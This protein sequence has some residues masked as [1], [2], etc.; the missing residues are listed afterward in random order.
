MVVSDR[1]GS[2]R[3]VCFLHPFPTLLHWMDGWAGVDFSCVA[4]RRQPFLFRVKG[5][6]PSPRRVL[7]GQRRHGWRVGECMEVCEVV[8]GSYV[9]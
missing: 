4:Q 5:C 2:K 1:V 8:I 6:V 9:G 3:D 7:V